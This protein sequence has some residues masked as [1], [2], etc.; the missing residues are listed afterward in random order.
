MSYTVNIRADNRHPGFSN[1]LIDKFTFRSSRA[2]FTFQSFSPHTVFIL[3]GKQCFDIQGELSYLHV[4]VLLAL[5]R[6]QSSPRVQRGEGEKM[7]EAVTIRLIT[8]AGLTAKSS[9]ERG[10]KGTQSDRIHSFFQKKLA[11]RLSQGG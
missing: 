8:D 5:L 6:F 7:K 10:S 2:L 1:A 3:G 11:G 9:R 4:C